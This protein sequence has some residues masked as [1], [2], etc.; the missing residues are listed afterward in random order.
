MKSREGQ[1]FIIVAVNMAQNS[2]AQ[3]QE[4]PNHNFPPCRHIE[5][6]TIKDFPDKTEKQNSL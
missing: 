1:S 6:K 4:S 2:A 3:V 5:T